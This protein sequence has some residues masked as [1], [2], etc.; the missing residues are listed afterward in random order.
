MALLHPHF[1][2]SFEQA[3][4]SPLTDSDFSAMYIMLTSPL[5]ALKSI[6]HQISGT[7]LMLVGNKWR[8]TK[9]KKS[10]LY[11]FTDNIC[12]MKEWSFFGH[13]F[14]MKEILPSNCLNHLP[15]V[16]VRYTC[17]KVPSKYSDIFALKLSLWVSDW[18]SHDWKLSPSIGYCP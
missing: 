10:V 8:G 6:T 13:L 9:T 1:Y 11:F 4:K 14:Y 18:V 2:T 17:L 12:C 15:S 3:S 7:K 16:L 5:C